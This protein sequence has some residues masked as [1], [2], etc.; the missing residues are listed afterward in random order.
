MKTKLLVLFFLTTLMK[1]GQ[2]QI[3]PSIQKIVPQKGNVGTVV[4]IYGT[5]FSA[6]ADSN[7]VFFG[8]IAAKAVWGSDAQG[9]YLQATV[10]LGATSAPIQVT[11]NKRSCTSSSA[12]IV[13]FAKS[14]QAFNYSSFSSI[15]DSIIG[16]EKSQQV[17]AADINGDGTVEFVV[18][19]ETSSFFT[20][21][22]TKSTSKPQNF[23]TDAVY[24]GGTNKM[25]ICDINGDGKPDV[26]ITRYGFNTGVVSVYRN[27]STIDSISFAAESNFVIANFATD[28][29]LG[30]LNNDGK[31]DLLVTNGNYG[32]NN[33]SLIMFK[34]TSNDNQINFTEAGQYNIG[35]FS[36]SICISDLNN[37]GKAD[38]AVAAYLGNNIYIL[39]N[40][41]KDSN[42][43]L[44]Y[45]PTINSGNTPFNLKCADLDGDG[46]NDLI[47]ANLYFSST[48][49]IFKNTSTDSGNITF[50][51]RFTIPNIDNPYAIAINDFN[52]DGL[53][54]LAVSSNN[55]LNLFKNKSSANG[56][57][58]DKEV[59]Y[60]SNS[61]I[62]DITSGDFNS[63]GK[64]DIAFVSFSGF[65]GL[66]SW[67]TATDVQR[68]VITSISPLIAKPGDKITING[69]NFS[70]TALDNTI[71]F[72]GIPVDSFVTASLTK[73]E[74]IVPKSAPYGHISVTVNALTALSPLAFNANF[75]G[76]TGNFN[77]N[78][79]VKRT[80]TLMD[81]PSTA[82]IAKLKKDSL[83]DIIIPH[84]YTPNKIG[85]FNYNNSPAA[86][87]NNTS[88][89]TVG[90][91]NS[92]QFA[93]I[94]GDGFTDLLQSN[95]D[96]GMIYI[97]INPANSNMG[98]I[99]T[100]IK[101]MTQPQTF[102][103]G[104]ADN[105]GKP[106]LF[107][108]GN[109]TS[110]ISVYKNT[111]FKDTIAFVSA[112]S[113][114]TQADVNGIALADLDGDGKQD[115]C[116]ISSLQIMAT[117]R[118]LSSVNSISFAAKQ[119]VSTS[120]I[121]Y[122]IKTGD[123]D[124]DGKTDLAVVT[125][126]NAYLS[127][128][129][130]KSSIGAINVTS[131]T[132]IFIGDSRAQL[133]IGDLDGDGKP[134]IAV[135]NGTSTVFSLF[136]NISDTAI[137]FTPKTDIT[138]GNTSGYTTETIAIH[139]V[140]GDNKPDII[141]STW[142]NRVLVFSNETSIVLPAQL[143]YFIA[144]PTQNQQTILQW[145]ISN[146]KELSSFVLEKKVNEKFIPIANI[147][148][149]VQNND[150]RYL[151]NNEYAYYR[152]QLLNSDGS[153]SYSPVLIVGNE[154]TINFRVYPNPTSTYLMIEGASKGFT[155]Q[156]LGTGKILLQQQYAIQ[157]QK[158][159]DVS[160][161]IN[162]SYVIT[163]WLPNGTIKQQL[164][165]KQ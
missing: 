42:I 35:S 45:M 99:K 43:V 115:I 110:A 108:A 5:S 80:D 34:N 153:I 2:S 38:V 28:L 93:D 147:N 125:S 3:P 151:V 96:S 106:D 48:L 92:T 160:H 109:G 84:L 40:N 17:I 101:V 59:F 81:G 127:V 162:G 158:K 119:E 94:D 29:A 139:D 82:L 144:K 102:A 155:I 62:S 46:K 136:R 76:G 165:T 86:L 112:G 8:S 116:L 85:I 24:K 25:H 87:I 97:Y 118:N 157:N 105:D 26:A 68:P 88:I 83:P 47:C 141:V 77:S 150:F 18:S 131:K 152:L 107:V 104:D 121:P 130:N 126:S 52:G 129:K 75:V 12:F 23:I 57:L 55:Y 49:S 91:I 58:F 27:T 90:G 65:G 15:K 122:Q 4:K 56:F 14:Y 132:D 128:Y 13:T 124:T 16:G 64:T 37:D 41:S 161:L 145:S 113:F 54:D 164:F 120:G 9:P 67:M 103:V 89:A 71:H 31:P 137:K 114:N 100:G 22:N 21:L 72:G 32:S 20:V 154:G 117:L 98:W 60:S 134:D 123:F 53:M 142:N 30:D 138:T 61:T 135:N 159:V 51:S 140:T 163:Y 148:I 39:K 6:N 111:T 95:S 69:T 133:A 44:E 143:L 146:P 63:D 36:R 156:A 78:S 11:V 74:V 66:L 7:W 19:Y 1:K 73:L 10:P 50:T 149:A 79:F 33:Y 70:N